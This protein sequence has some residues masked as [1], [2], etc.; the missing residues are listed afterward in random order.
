[1]KFKYLLSESCANKKIFYIA[2]IVQYCLQLAFFIL[3]IKYILDFPIL[4]L[5]NLSNS[6]NW[7]TEKLRN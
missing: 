1:M 3:P 4:N 2:F 6:T 7:I 5:A